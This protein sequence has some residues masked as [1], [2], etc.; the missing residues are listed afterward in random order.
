M[1]IIAQL[2]VEMVIEKVVKDVMM[3]IKLEEMGVLQP[4]L[5]K[6]D[7]VVIQQPQ[8]FAPRVAL[9]V[10]LEENVDKTPVIQE[11]AE[12]AQMLMVQ[13]HVQMEY[14]LLAAIPVMMTAMESEPMDVKPL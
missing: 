11:A 4:A 3:V 14:V 10:A 13:I 1:T 8:M 12:V 6:A 7:G 5:L 9:L 2:Y